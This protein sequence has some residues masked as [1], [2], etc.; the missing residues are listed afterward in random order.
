MPPPGT[1]GDR[2]TGHPM[3]WGRFQRRAARVRAMLQVRSE[4]RLADVAELGRS[5]R[6]LR[7]IPGGRDVARDRCGREPFAFKW[8]PITRP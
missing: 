3:G 5:R 8:V 1:A 4:G 7:A 2:A 6:R